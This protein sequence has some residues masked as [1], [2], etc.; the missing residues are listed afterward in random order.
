MSSNLT[1]IK[2]VVLFLLLV[3]FILFLQNHKTQSFI[4]KEDGIFW[5]QDT[6]NE[7]GNWVALWSEYKLRKKMTDHEIW[8]E[9]L[10]YFQEN[11]ELSNQSKMILK[12]LRKTFPEA[13]YMIY[14][15]NCESTGLV[16]LTK[17][18]GLLPNTNGGSDRGV[19]QIHMG[20]HRAEINRLGLNMKKY[21]DYFMFS[22]LLYDRNGITPWKPSRHCWEE[23][24]QRIMMSYND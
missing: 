4:E 15:A 20:T 18:G 23:H 1:K 11:Y 8:E 6:D 5:T 24:Y 16:H 2:L 7:S 14:I 19:L 13:P 22:R 21:N 12:W 3:S 9:E 10:E 17:T